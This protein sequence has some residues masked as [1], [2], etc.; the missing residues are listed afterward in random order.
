MSACD[1]ACTCGACRGIRTETP[2]AI[3]NRPGL[4]A[5]RYRVGDHTRFKASLLAGISRGVPPTLRSRRTRDDDDFSIALLDAFALMADVLTFYQERIANESYLRTSTE[6]LSVGHIARL[7]GYDL[8]P[9]SAAR[10][11]LA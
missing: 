5:I 4:A 3:E 8:R 11:I 2:L 7:I 1:V 9:G 10:T 6:L